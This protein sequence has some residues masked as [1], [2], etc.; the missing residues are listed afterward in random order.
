MNKLKLG[1]ELKL[2]SAT[3]KVASISRKGVLFSLCDGK[4]DA[5]KE[6]FLTLE[7]VESLLWK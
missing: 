3:Y 4:L 1:S 2:F 7:E 6:L 5:A